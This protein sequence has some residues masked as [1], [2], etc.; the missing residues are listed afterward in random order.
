MRMRRV[1]GK[2]KFYLRADDIS[3]AP[4]SSSVKWSLQYL[5]FFMD[6]FIK[7]STQTQKTERH[8]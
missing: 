4:V 8:I 6:C 3:I 7:T 1:E 2:E 5:E